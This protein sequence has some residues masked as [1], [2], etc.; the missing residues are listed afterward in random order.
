MP[1]ELDGLSRITHSRVEGL[2]GALP[3]GRGAPL[4]PNQLC[5]MVSL[6]W[7]LEKKDR[8]QQFDT[9]YPCSDTAFSRVIFLDFMETSGRCISWGELSGNEWGLSSNACNEVGWPEALPLQ[10]DMVESR[11]CRLNQDMKSCSDSWETC[12]CPCPGEIRNH[13]YL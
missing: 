9:H 6:W 10:A 13:C 12:P 11:C 2:P 5:G 3:E 4:W 1:L 7:A 8:V